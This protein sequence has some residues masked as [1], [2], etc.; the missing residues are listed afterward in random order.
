MQAILFQEDLAPEKVWVRLSLLTE[1]DEIFGVLLNEP[2]GDYE[3]HEGSLIEIAEIVKDDRKFLF[4][5]GR[6][7]ERMLS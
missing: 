2:I 1:N 4:F 6:T 3:C 7:M 5:T